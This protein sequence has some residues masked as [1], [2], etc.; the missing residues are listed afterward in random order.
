MRK[1][2]AVEPDIHLRAGMWATDGKGFGTVREVSGITTSKP[3]VGKEEI[4]V[5]R[6]VRIRAEVHLRPMEIRKARFVAQIDEEVL[7]HLE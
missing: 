5:R 3:F 7:P 4:G 6:E 2:G 1:Y